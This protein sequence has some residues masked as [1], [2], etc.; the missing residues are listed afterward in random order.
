[1]GAETGLR[2][3]L[4]DTTSAARNEIELIG[5][6][7]QP[8]ATTARQTAALT[9]RQEAAA[10]LFPRLKTWFLGERRDYIAKQLIERDPVLGRMLDEGVIKVSPRFLPKGSVMPDVVYTRAPVW[11][12]FTTPLAW[13]EHVIRYTGIYGEGIPIFY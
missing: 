11:W 2:S 7:L 12:D 5:S 3:A 10:G 6:R 8:I 9:E 4:G 13:D 1:L